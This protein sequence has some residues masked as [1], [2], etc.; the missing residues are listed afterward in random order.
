E[1]A[2]TQ[3]L[4]L[5]WG[6]KGFSLNVNLQG[7]DVPL[8]YGYPPDC[9]FKQS[10]YTGLVGQGG[11]LSKV[12]DPQTLANVV[13]TASQAT[14]LFIPA[15]REF[16]CLINRNFSEAEIASLLS[17]ISKMAAEIKKYGL[18]GELENSG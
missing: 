5:H 18:N 1:L 2:K 8:C 14:G 6:T 16:K 12:A 10:I 17:W 7:I 11:T 4:P 3:S 9:V 13:A 15:G